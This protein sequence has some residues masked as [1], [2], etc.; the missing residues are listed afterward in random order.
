MGTQLGRHTRLKTTPLFE[1]A[2]ASE[3]PGR[4]QQNS[5]KHHAGS[6][7]AHRRNT[8]LTTPLPSGLADSGGANGGLRLQCR[9]SS[10]CIALKRRMLVSRES[11]CADSSE[12]S[13][14]RLAGLHAP[15]RTGVASCRIWRI[16]RVPNSPPGQGRRGTKDAHQHFML[17]ATAQARV[18]SRI[19]P[20]LMAR[21]ACV[22]MP[23]AHPHHLRHCCRIS[24]REKIDCCNS[25]TRRACGSCITPLPSRDRA[26]RLDSGASR[27]DSP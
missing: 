10:L 13:D 15:H 26:H 21:A 11:F 8:W 23:R 19:L 25:E 27:P 3:A 12:A 18:E 22:T 1:T 9:T 4:V 2:N 6:R 17:P 7:T 24:I 16:P 5:P 20:S 14:T